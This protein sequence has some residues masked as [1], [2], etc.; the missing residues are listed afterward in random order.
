MISLISRPPFTFFHFSFLLTLYDLCGHFEYNKP[1]FDNCQML[2]VF[3]PF[4][5][6]LAL[7]SFFSF[8][9][10]LYDL[11]GHFEYNEPKFY[12]NFFFSRFH[13]IAISELIFVYKW[14]VFVTSTHNHLCKEKNTVCPQGL[15]AV[16]SD[17]DFC[18][19]TLVC[20]YKHFQSHK[21]K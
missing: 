7:F 14:F 3:P 15:W 11:C 21:V 12:D 5:G 8:L 10:T 4:L 1:I 9:L 13:S 6:P 19:V 2:M 18:G 20:G 16:C 17:S